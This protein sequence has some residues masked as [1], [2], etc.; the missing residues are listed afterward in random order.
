MQSL[1]LQCGICRRELPADW[2]RS[3]L[4]I[5]R[6]TERYRGAEAQ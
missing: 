3:V 6:E 2:R 1:H 4:G 5:T